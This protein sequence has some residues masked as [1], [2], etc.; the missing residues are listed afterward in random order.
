[1]P[2][3]TFDFRGTP[4]A[5]VVV[6]MLS[7]RSVA[8][9]STYRNFSESHSPPKRNIKITKPEDLTLGDLGSAFDVFVPRKPVRKCVGLLADVLS[10]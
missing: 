8:L 5:L 2:D 9:G 6:I 4:I 1:M 3:F 10:I 7:K